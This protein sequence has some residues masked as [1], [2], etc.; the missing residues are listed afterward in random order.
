LAN[1]LESAACKHR[2]AV[3]ALGS[4]ATARQPCVGTIQHAP[5]PSAAAPG[6]AH[7]GCGSRTDHERTTRAGERRLAHATHHSTATPAHLR[8]LCCRGPNTRGLAIDYRSQ[9]SPRPRVAQHHPRPA[10]SLPWPAAGRVALARAGRTKP[11]TRSLEPGVRLLTSLVRQTT[12][13]RACNSSQPSNRA[14]P[15]PGGGQQPPPRA[16][17]HVRD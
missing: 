7:S 16:S 1:W 14:R 17:R 13:N 15:R 5:G 11:D 4:R 12:V 3:M 9:P 2:T 10:T 8:C 6:R